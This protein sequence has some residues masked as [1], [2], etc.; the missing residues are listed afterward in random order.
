MTQELIDLM[1]DSLVIGRDNF[2]AQKILNDG[3][4]EIGKFVDSHG[5]I[6]DIDFGTIKRDEIMCMMVADFSLQAIKKGTT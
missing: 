1:N 4:D 5:Y 6:N 3:W 2:Q